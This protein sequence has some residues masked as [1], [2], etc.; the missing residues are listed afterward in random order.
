MEEK[1]QDIL[2]TLKSIGLTEGES[3]TYL[4][5]LSIGTSTVGP[6]VEKAS[7]SSS[8][9][10]IILDKLIHKGLVG[11]VIKNGK[12]NYTAA[13]PEKIIDYLNE[14]QQKVER[15][16]MLAKKILPE[17]RLKKGSVSKLPIVELTKGRKGTEMFYDEVYANLKEGDEYIAT[18]GTRISFKLQNYWFKQSEILAKMKI[19]QFLAYEYDVWHKKDPSA[20]KRKKRKN[21]F[22]KILDKKY[23]DL[24]TIITI[25]NYSVVS[26]LDDGGELFTLLIRNKNLTNALKRLLVVVRD[27]GNVPEGFEEKFKKN[28]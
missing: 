14:E 17:L 26:D 15:N 16:K 1:E 3:K 24:P 27:S 21:Y 2:E 12:K 22:P 23:K 11:I 5:L 8:K 18:S 28:S 7:V 6:I 19:P 20:H 10:Y 9:V 4:A 13:Q 25:G